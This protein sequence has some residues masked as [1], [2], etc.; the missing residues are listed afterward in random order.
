V[1]TG[2]K[3]PSK[4]DVG[5]N[6][7]KAM[8]TWYYDK[9][10]PSGCGKDIFTSDV[11]NYEMMVSTTDVF[12]LEK[13]QPHISVKSEAFQWLVYENCEEKWGNICTEWFANREFKVPNFSKK[14]AS[15]HPYNKTKWSDSHSGQ[16]SG[17]GWKPSAFIQLNLN[18]K[19]I[20]EF[21]KKEHHGNG[22]DRKSQWMWNK[23]MKGWV[24]QSKGIT[25]KKPNKKRKRGTKQLA[26][27]K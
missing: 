2:N 25:D 1:A 21:R 3:K 10:V 19:L 12:G 4:D 6:Q 26:A 13:K 15:T 8:A 20:L 7:Y 11:R 24:R 22:N 5:F 17:G 27:G 18:Q 16:I 23:I 14:N 9:L